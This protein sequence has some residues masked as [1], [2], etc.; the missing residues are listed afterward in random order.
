MVTPEC[1]VERSA[2][3]A[4]QKYFHVWLSAR[5]HTRTSP[6]MEKVIQT[7]VDLSDMQLILSRVTLRTSPRLRI[8]ACNTIRWLQCRSRSISAILSSHAS[9]V[10]PA[11]CLL[12]RTH[13]GNVQQ[14]VRCLQ[15]R[16]DAYLS[17]DC[18]TEFQHGHAGSGAANHWR[19]CH[20]ETRGNPTHPVPPHAS[21]NVARRSNAFGDRHVRVVSSVGALILDFIKL[22]MLWS[23]VNQG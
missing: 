22:G 16:N 2:N 10:F 23:D 8:S 1:K 12:P 14:N 3:N 11:F 9:R 4:S 17:S 6:T 19:R 15:S 20:T 5:N 18:N 13:E 21:T 7:V